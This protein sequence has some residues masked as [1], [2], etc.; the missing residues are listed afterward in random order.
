MT[1]D[2]VCGMNVDE[3]KAQY[4]SQY[5]GKKYNF[6]SEQCKKEFDRQPEQYA[7]AAA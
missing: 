2:P 3:N 5:G 4:Q 6:S 1:Q 7:R